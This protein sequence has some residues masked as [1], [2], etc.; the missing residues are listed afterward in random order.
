MIGALTGTVFYKKANSLVLMV[1]GVGYTVSVPEKLF[2]KTKTG[3]KLDVHIYTHVR[4]DT[5]ELYGFIQADERELFELLLSVSGIGPKTALSIMNRG[6][7]DIRQ[8]VAKA[9]VGFFTAIPR[10]GTKNAQK[11]IIEL[12]SKLGNLVEL[13]LTGETI[14]ETLEIMNALTAFGFS[15]VEARAV[16]GQLPTNALTLEQKVKAALKLLGKKA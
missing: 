1:Q 13:D 3:D 15:Q 9:D 2:L 8:A 5:L 12:K 4:Q 10:L 11:V 7:A 6:V 16:V 14:G